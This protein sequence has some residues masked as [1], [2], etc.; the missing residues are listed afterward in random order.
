MAVLGAAA[1]LQADDALDLDL[2][3]APPHPDVVGQ[4]E[5]FVEVLVVQLQ[6]GQHL[7][8]GQ[9]LAS[10]Q[11]LRTGLGQDVAQ[12]LAPHLKNLNSVQV[13]VARCSPTNAMW[14]TPRPR[15]WTTSGSPTCP[16]AGWA[17]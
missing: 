15:S 12:T 13:M 2:R 4:R 6:D 5:Q 10:F 3:A 8:L 1:G 9:A 7:V 14:S 16:C 11:H 17:A